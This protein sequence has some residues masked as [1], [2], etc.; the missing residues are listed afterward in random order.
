[1]SHRIDRRSVSRVMAL[2]SQLVRIFHFQKPQ[3]VFNDKWC[4]SLAQVRHSEF[5]RWSS[6]GLAMDAFFSLSSNDVYEWDTKATTAHNKKKKKS[7]SSFGILGMFLWLFNK[8]TACAYNLT[9]F[10][11]GLFLVHAKHDWIFSSLEC[12]RF[13]WLAELAELLTIPVRHTDEIAQRL[14]GVDSSKVY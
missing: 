12:V 2:N 6:A 3:F 13:E 1:M 10:W 5:L 8:Q 7:G 9:V 11:S 4:R 14:C